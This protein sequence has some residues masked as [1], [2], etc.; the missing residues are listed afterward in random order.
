MSNYVSI[1]F[2]WLCYTSLVR[3]FDLICRIGTLG[4]PAYL[5]RATFNDAMRLPNPCLR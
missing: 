4:I 2:V 5:I 1:T 3:L